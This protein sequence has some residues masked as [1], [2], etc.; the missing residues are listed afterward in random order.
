MDR[1][2]FAGFR[3]SDYACWENNR[4]FVSLFVL[5]SVLGAGGWV[6]IRLLWAAGKLFWRQP[7][8]HRC[9]LLTALLVCWAVYVVGARGW[10]YW[11]TPTPRALALKLRHQPGSPDFFI[12]LTNTAW[13]PIEVL[14]P[15]YCCQ[16]VTA[17]KGGA[18]AFTR[19]PLED[20]TFVTLRG[21]G[22]LSWKL[23][24]SNLCLLDQKERLADLASLTQF[25]VQVTKF[26]NEDPVGVLNRLKPATLADFRDQR[27]LARFDTVVGH[28]VNGNKSSA[29]A[30]QTNLT[31]RA[32]STP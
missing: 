20:G 22:T 21:H 32:E 3:L 1:T 24:V 14:N 10:A 29:R 8:M 18:K 15:E 17:G 11:A 6:I 23:S 30:F 26:T 12:T 5:L 19:I 28:E 16:I 25:L 31:L 7:A 2:R 9:L 13:Q 4:N 27:I